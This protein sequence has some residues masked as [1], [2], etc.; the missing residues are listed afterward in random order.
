MLYKENTNIERWIIEPLNL[1]GVSLDLL[2]IGELV[3]IFCDVYLIVHG[4]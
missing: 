2:S 4:M 1:L 3:K